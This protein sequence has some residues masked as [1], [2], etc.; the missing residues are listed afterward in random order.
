MNYSQS[1]YYLLSSSKDSSLKIWDLREGR[2]LFT[3]QSH[4]GPVNSAQFSADGNF[5][6]SGGAD[7]LVMIWKSN[8]YGVTA[9]EVDWGM[10]EKPRTPANITS[11][12]PREAFPTSAPVGKQVESTGKSSRKSTPEAK[13]PSTAPSAPISRPATNP[14][15]P[16]PTTTRMSRRKQIDPVPASASRSVE[17]PQ[18]EFKN[19]Q[20]LSRSSIAAT[21]GNDMSSIRDVTFQQS[22]RSQASSAPLSAALSTNLLNKLEEIL[23][24]VSLVMVDRTCI[25]TLLTSFDHV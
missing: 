23:G 16:S 25:A 5:F 11:N 6:A 7:E 4:A 13:R 2:L 8:L 21:P 20:E 14:R 18:S 15:K 10:G 9:P 19:S 22:V 1:G 24:E 3:L 12:F 17:R